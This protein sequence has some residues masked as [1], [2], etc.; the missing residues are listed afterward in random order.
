MN[1]PVLKDKYT[2]D[3][4][5]D[6][7]TAL[8]AEDGCPWDKVQTHETLKKCMIEE[9]YE[10][11]D[12]LDA[13]DDA[14]FA[15]ELGDVLLQVAFHAQIAKERGAFDFDRVLSELC[16]KLITR[17]THVFGDAKASN[18]EEALANWEQNKKKEK[19]SGSSAEVLDEVPH[20]LP[21]LLR[22]EKVQKKAASFGTDFGDAK[23]TAAKLQKAA[24]GLLSD[25]EENKN[26]SASFRK[27]L[28]A[29]VCLGRQL[30]LTPETELNAATNDFI[31]KFSSAETAEK[32][33]DSVF[34]AIFLD[35]MNIF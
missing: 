25:I 20:H 10:A 30:G 19:K 31:E 11:I 12:A 3:D 32:P 2:I 9:V 29:A 6:I 21:A 15:N 5:F 8:R 14:L 16:T 4:L 17:H 24:S 35:E 23:E 1:K 13:G 27:I 26:P 28:L 7:L 33:V 34:Q 22:A 18:A